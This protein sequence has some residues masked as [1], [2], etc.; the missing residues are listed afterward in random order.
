MPALLIKLDRTRSYSLTTAFSDLPVIISLEIHTNFE[1]QQ[2]MV[3]IMKEVWHGFLISPTPDAD[4]VAKSPLPSP[5]DLRRKI[6]VKVKYSSPD[7]AKAKKLGELSAQPDKHQIT[8]GSDDEAPEVKKVKKRKILDSLSELGV[9]THAYSFK[10]FDKPE[11]K[12]PT[13]V[14]SLSEKRLLDSDGGLTPAVCTHNKVSTSP[15]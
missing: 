15:A 14:F 8:S 12:I 1:Q 13:H 4:V 9:Y 5:A 3:D 7:T 11:A 2:I 6:L 10:G